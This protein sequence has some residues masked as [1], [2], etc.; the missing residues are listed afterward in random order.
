[1]S[2]NPGIQHGDSKGR[3]GGRRGCQLCLL[4]SCPSA[5]W[6]ATAPTSPCAL[7]WPSSRTPDR[8]RAEDALS[9]VGTWV[10]RP[11]R[12]GAAKVRHCSWFIQVSLAVTAL[13]AA[14]LQAAD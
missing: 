13:E 1:M 14:L 6:F 2:L 8:A 11:P 9:A 3:R 10:L 4:L 5:T 7:L 12:L